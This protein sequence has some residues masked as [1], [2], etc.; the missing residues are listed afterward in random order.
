MAAKLLDN[1]W[2][3]GAKTD[4]EDLINANADKGEIAIFDFDNTI[5]CRDIGEA[6]FDQLIDENKIKIDNIPDLLK[7][8]FNLSGETVKLTYQD[9]IANYYEKF[10]QATEHQIY[11]SCPNSGSYAWVVQIMAGISVSDIVQY[12]DKAYNYGIA[13]LDKS[14]SKLFVT[15]IQNY[16]RPFFNI[17]MADL[18]GLLNKNGYRV[19][20]VSASNVWSVRWMVLNYLNPLIESMHGSSAVINPLNINGTRVLLKEKS[21]GILYKDFYLAQ[22]NIDYARMNADAI[23]EYELTGIIDYPLPACHGKVASILENI[24]FEKPFLVCGDSPNDFSMLRYAENKLWIARL[25]K[26]SFH[27]ELTTIIE[28]GINDSSWIIQPALINQSPGFVSSKS[29]L[30]N[31]I[32]HDNALLQTAENSLNILLN[33]GRLQRF[34]IYNTIL[35]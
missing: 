16:P 8:T 1:G 13:S 12:T 24:S 35:I 20:I 7:P 5:L 6:L 25:E 9:E 3:S 21:S 15:K 30:L 4:L 33:T 28:S 29:M 14:D 11:D 32:H 18:I 22:E 17:E 27:E 23:S 10:C 31:R 26:P 19:Y 34:F 2:Y